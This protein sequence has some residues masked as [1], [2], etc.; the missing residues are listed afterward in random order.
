ML[1]LCSWKVH[2]GHPKTQ[3]QNVREFGKMMEDS[4]SPQ[5]DNNLLQSILEEKIPFSITKE[6]K[7]NT[8]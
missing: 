3:Y 5:T 7:L 1:R 8:L 4:T 6:K 2:N